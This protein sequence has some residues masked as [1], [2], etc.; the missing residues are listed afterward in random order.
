MFQLRYAATPGRQSCYPQTRPVRFSLLRLR[1]IVLTCSRGLVQLHALRPT[2]Q[3]TG[4]SSMPAGS[5]MQQAV[6]FQTASVVSSTPPRPAIN[7]Q[8]DRLS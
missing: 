5:P 3:T 6:R 7:P 8:A 1:H 2:A 4:Q